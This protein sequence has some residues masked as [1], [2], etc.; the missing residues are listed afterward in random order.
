MSDPEIQ[1][2]MSKKGRE[3]VQARI[4]K[5]KARIMERARREGKV[6]NDDVEDLFCISDATSRNYL[7]ELEAEG[8]LT[9]VGTTG[10]GVH[11]T[12]NVRGRASNISPNH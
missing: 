8:A 6:T 1:K 10:R 2:A 5:R 9:Q 4:A 11:Y 3:A 12:P 7:N